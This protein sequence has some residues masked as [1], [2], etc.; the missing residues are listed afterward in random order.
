[1][2]EN[3][4]QHRNPFGAL[5]GAALDMPTYVVR[6]AQ[7][8]RT[9]MA[10]VAASRPAR[11]ALTRRLGACAIAVSVM[12]A[13]WVTA[14]RSERLRSSWAATEEVIVATRDLAVGT[15]ITDTDTEVQLRPAELVPQGAITDAPEP[16]SVATAFTAGGEP[17]VRERI[18]TGGSTGVEVPPGLVAVEVT[19]ASATNLAAV[20]DQVDVLAV[21]PLTGAPGAGIHGVIDDLEPPADAEAGDAVVVAGGATVLAVARNEDVGAPTVTLAV[22]STDVQTAVAAALAGPVA[23]VVRGPGD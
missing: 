2:H 10:T 17:M 22:R 18:G 11:R 6:L 19:P 21:A 13:T 15:P 20:G 9:A 1:V 8:L 4:H 14:D 23:I 3:D 5:T 7:R 16:G 12:V